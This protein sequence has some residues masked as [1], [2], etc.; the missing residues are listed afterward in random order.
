MDDRVTIMPYAPEDASAFRA[1]NLTW[2][3]RHFV[4]EPHDR[5]QL[6]DPQTHILTVGGTIL[7]ARCGD[8]V[9]GVCAVIPE[10]ADR[11]ELAKMAVDPAFQGRGIGGQLCDAAVDWARTRGA[12]SLWLESNRRLASAL[13]V[14]RR[15]GFEEVPL[16]P[17]P[18]ER[19]DIRMEKKL[20]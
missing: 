3:G 9:V 2:I 14:Y 13:R 18:Y 16:V 11:Y 17:S 19:A 1:L 7:V 8:S 4:V 15:A 20:R 12:A 6:D 5:E 10:G